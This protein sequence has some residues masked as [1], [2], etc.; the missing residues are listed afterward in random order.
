MTFT[1]PVA[2]AH[3]N[4]LVEI[5]HPAHVH[6]FRHPIRIWRE[7]G[8]QVLI[9]TRDKEITHALLDEIG[10]EYIPL[11]KQKMH[12]WSQAIELVSQWIKVFWIIRR[13]K[14]DVAISITGLF[15]TVPA[16]L[17]G[18]VSISDTDTE[19]DVLAHRIA[20]PFSDVVL[21]PAAFLRQAKVPNLV[22][23]NAFHELAYL[24]PS[25]FTPD[26]HYLQDFHISEHDQF[27]VIRLVRWNALHD[28]HQKGISEDEL[29]EMIRLYEREGY[30]VL[31]SS[32]R[33]LSAALE[34]YLLT[35]H[36]SRIFHLLAFS[37]GYIGESPTMAMEAAI[38]GRPSVLIT[39]R[40]P[41]L[42]YTTEMQQKYGLLHA[43]DCFEQARPFLQHEFLSERVYDDIARG[44]EQLFSEN[45]DLSEW[46]AQ[47]TI[48]YA[49]DR[50]RIRRK[51]SW[52]LS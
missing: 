29:R 42:G 3:L 40:A 24:H 5:S 34:P 50:S 11:S 6:F 30:R 23:Y 39:S 16:R 4:I 49:T 20:F 51:Q 2:A 43:F 17:A 9:V 26:R 36:F 1:H 10:L 41:Y 48:E 44:R 25:R 32:E 22:T 21:T 38:L 8:H 33:P 37:K 18:I 14:I 47:F 45:I 27:L 28:I 15:T 13:R 12:L 46:L 35:G 52:P 19:D 31:V 7:H